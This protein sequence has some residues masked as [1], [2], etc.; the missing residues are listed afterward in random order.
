MWMVQCSIAMARSQDDL[1]DALELLN[2][3]VARA[4][5]SGV[6]AEQLDP[7]S[8]VPIN[9]SPPTWS[10]AEMVITTHKY[11]SKIRELERKQGD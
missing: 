7:Y 1:R 6:L 8:G 4:L 2:W 3:A 10:H 9:I 11:L 5:P